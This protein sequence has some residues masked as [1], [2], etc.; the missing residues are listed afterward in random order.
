[1]RLTAELRYP[2]ASPQSVFAMMTERTFQERTCAATGSLVYEVDVATYADGG[3]RISTERTLPTDSVPE[4]VRR[5]V[6][7]TVRV[8]RH[9][10]WQPADAEGRRRGEIVVEIM[11][12]P[13]RLTG[14][15]ALDVEAGGVVVRV[16]GDLKASVPLIGGTIER[17]AEPAIEAAIRV[18]QRVGLQ[19]LAENS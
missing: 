7:G 15:L 10:D 1:M 3:A 16:D 2:D 6:G 4:F 11:G 17:S 5:F 13:V 18:E 12:A 19:W 8:A 9:D 14:T